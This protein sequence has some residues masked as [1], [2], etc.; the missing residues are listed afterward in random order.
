M[1]WKFWTIASVLALAACADDTAT[2]PAAD[3]AAAPPDAVADAGAPAAPAPEPGTEGP[4]GAAP[5]P[6]PEGDAMT[7]NFAETA[8]GPKLTYGEPRTDN[9]RLML[10]CAGGERIALSFLRGS[11]GEGPM[12]VRSG[13]ASETVPA[14]AEATQLGGVSV[15]AEL[16]ATAPPLERFRGGSALAVEYAGDTRNVPPAGPEADRFFSAC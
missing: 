10:R 4:P 13:G 7:W 8:A 1:T 5:A 11:A 9:V 15:R 16:A 3:D 2:E 6:P 14:E 12:T